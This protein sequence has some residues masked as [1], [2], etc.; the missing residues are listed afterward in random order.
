MTVSGPGTKKQ[1]LLWW[2]LLTWLDD[3]QDGIHGGVRQ[4]L[5]C[6][7][8]SYNWQGVGG[9]L[10]LSDVERII[11]HEVIRDGM[12]CLLHRP[13][14]PQAGLQLDGVRQVEAGHA[15]FLG[16]DHITVFVQQLVHIISP[17]FPYLQP[18]EHL[19]DLKS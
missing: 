9:W 7:V 3:D 18:G 5:E 16:R 19:N 14:K 8:L 12:G 2:L 13:A 6:V 10:H 4:E 17:R 15:C 11:F 1:T